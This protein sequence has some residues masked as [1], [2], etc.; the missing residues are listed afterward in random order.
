MILA[1]FCA[2]LSGSLAQDEV[3]AKASATRH[4][5]ESISYPKLS[6]WRKDLTRP[7][8]EVENAGKKG[9]RITF[10]YDTPSEVEQKAHG[11]VDPER[12]EA[13]FYQHKAD[14]MKLMGDFSCKTP[15][16]SGPDWTERSFC[17]RHVYEIPWG[18]NNMSEAWVALQFRDH[19]FWVEIPYGFTRDPEDPLGWDG[20]TGRAAFPIP[21]GELTRED[22]VIPWEF[23]TYR[24]D[25]LPKGVGAWV[26]IANPFDASVELGFSRMDGDVRAPRAMVAVS[27]R[28]EQAAALGAPRAQDW[29][30][31]GYC[32]ALALGPDSTRTQ[33]YHFPRCNLNSDARQWGT[34]LLT[35]GNSTRN[36]AIPS[37]LF[38]YV[39]G[40]APKP[41]DAA[42]VELA[43]KWSSE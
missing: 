34:L 23:V 10:S 19:R 32:T 11:K 3:P 5:W 38:Q 42:V 29:K 28:R 35:V 13:H 20:S 12:V 31:N 24:L 16:G 40:H 4:R 26:N 25:D 33:L 6:P 2:L 22:L 14:A 39:H 17:C 41:L 36:F 9:M 15:D 8:V 1:V 7:K 27:A 37:S 21:R 30:M 18:P 43:E